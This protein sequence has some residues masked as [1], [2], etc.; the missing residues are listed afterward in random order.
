MV[1]LGLDQLGPGRVGRGPG[2]AHLLLELL[3]LVG[4]LTDGAGRE[5]GGRR[6]HHEERGQE[7]EPTHG[8][9]S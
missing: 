2:L 3:L 5:P 7:D 8:R 4:L 9:R 6:G 1:S